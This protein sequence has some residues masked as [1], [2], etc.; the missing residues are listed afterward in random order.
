MKL[1]EE[2]PYINLEFPTPP[3]ERPYVAMNMVMSIDGKATVGRRLETGSLGSAF[4]RYTMAVLRHHFDAV[5]CGGE[6][7][8]R[9]PYYLGV[10]PELVPYR[11]ER[12]LVPQPLAVVVTNSGRLP[13]PS[14]LFAQ[15]LRPIV[16]TSAASLPALTDAL[17]AAAHVHAAGS[18]R[19]EVPLALTLLRKQYGV[20]HL[21]LEGGP[22][23]NY[24][25]LKENAV[26]EVFITIA[27]RIVGAEDE[28]A[29]V[30]GSD[31]LTALPRLNLISCFRHDDELFL[32]YRF[33][34][35]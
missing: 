9:H 21:L 5:I 24:Q 25:F 20:E 18:T 6:T 10:F 13:Y 8:R 34:Q 1:P 4:D 7:M 26:D 22:R 2:H 33:P 19:V 11:Q 16:L 30:M 17:G 27:P 23:L 15:E 3:A 31:V 35:D 14:P 28:L 12:G 32:R 29:M